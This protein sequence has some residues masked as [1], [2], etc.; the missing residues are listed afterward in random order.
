M[1]RALKLFGYPGNLKTRSARQFFENLVPLW[2]HTHTY[3]IP[4]TSYSVVPQA[5]T[6]RF[7]TICLRERSR[8]S[9]TETAAA[10]DIEWVSAS[11]SSTY[12]HAAQQSAR[13]GVR[14][15][16]VTTAYPPSLPSLTRWSRDHP[17]PHSATVRR[18]GGGGDGVVFDRSAHRRRSG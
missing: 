2:T 10:A 5:K 16:V 12:I 4:C 13:K 11:S 9:W 8:P 17:P 15:P 6:R 18:L 3:I 14:R 7:S 1:N